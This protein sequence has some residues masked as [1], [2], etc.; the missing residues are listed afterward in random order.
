MLLFL[1]ILFTLIGS[2]FSL[3]GGL[4]LLIYKSWN[5][6]FSIKLVSFAAGVLLT[7]AFFDLLPEALEESNNNPNIFGIIFLVIIAFFFLERSFFFFHHHHEDDDHHH[8]MEPSVKLLLLGDT[9]HNFI[10]GI[11]IA[12]SFLVSIPL[13]I[14][15]SLAVAAHEIPQEIADFSIMKSKGLKNSQ[16]IK[17]NVFSALAALLGA[18][19][20]YLF[21]ASIEGYIWILLAAAGG[22]FIY[23]STADLIPEL[24][25]AYKKNRSISQSMFFI[26][27]IV[28]T[29]LFIKLVGLI[30]HV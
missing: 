29:I 4:L 10:D 2:L 24:H 7:T 9:V 12:A 18:V 22:M 16:A 15:T 21:A 28:V 30:V 25:H 19:L 6:S 13:G 1:I 14:L 8:G 23:I 17:F 3:I 11:V 5:E 27:G 26:L 20:T